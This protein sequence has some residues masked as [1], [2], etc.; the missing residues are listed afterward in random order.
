MESKFEEEVQEQIEQPYKIPLSIQLFLMLFT[1]LIT[2]AVLYKVRIP[3]KPTLLVKSSI[4]MFVIAFLYPIL[5]H[6][7]NR[8]SYTLAFALFGGAFVSMIL[9]AITF[10]NLRQRS[11]GLLTIAFLAIIGIELLHH[12]T[13]IFRTR[14]SKMIFIFDGVLAS[15]FFVIIFLLFWD[16][17]AGTLPWIDSI[18]IG[19]G[20]AILYFYAIL[21]EREF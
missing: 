18:L 21:P 7:E 17:F 10:L 2:I 5:I 6:I 20:L 9:L 1:C 15:F 14:K 4:F 12:T 13:S 19:I 8:I 16:G 3:L 11:N